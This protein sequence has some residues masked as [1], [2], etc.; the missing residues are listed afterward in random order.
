M[1]TGMY[2]TRSTSSYMLSLL[3]ANIL[4]PLQLQL[5]ILRQGLPR[6][7]RPPACPPP[8]S[9][10]ECPDRVRPLRLLNCRLYVPLDL[11]S[12]LGP[13]SYICDAKHHT[14][15]TLPQAEWHDTTQ[16]HQLRKTTLPYTRTL[17]EPSD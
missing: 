5:H 12:V 2:V 7:R 16:T 17:P 1:A 10:Q 6:R 3:S 8:I 13:Y 9:V 4:R 11:R 14:H 15:A